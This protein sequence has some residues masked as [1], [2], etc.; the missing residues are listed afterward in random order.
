MD[1]FLKISNN[2]SDFYLYLELSLF[3]TDLCIIVLCKVYWQRTIRINFNFCII[4]KKKYICNA[5]F[6]TYKISNSIANSIICFRT[7]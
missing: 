5:T 2:N 3:R 6:Y 7:K 4:V 1:I